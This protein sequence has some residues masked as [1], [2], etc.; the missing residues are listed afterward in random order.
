MNLSW[1]ISPFETLSPRA[2]H[3]ILRLRVDIFVVEQACAYA[4]VDGQDLEAEHIMACDEHG[5][6]LAYARILPASESGPAHIGRVVVRST[7]RGQGLGHQVMQ[8]ALSHLLES[9]GSRRS[10][11]AAQAPLEAFYAQYGFR[12]VGVDYDWDGIPHVDM[13][14]EAD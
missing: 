1:S 5:E 12:R 14:R 7:A 11:L 10:N 9:T 6:L 4:E 2:V 3:D 13:E 8:R